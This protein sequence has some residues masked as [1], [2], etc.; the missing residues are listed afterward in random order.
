V[1]TTDRA[2]G[3]VLYAGAAALLVAGGLWWVHAK[4]DE[5]ATPAVAAWRA[6][7]ERLLPAPP[8]AEAVDTV[9]LSVGLDR[10]ID[11]RV[12]NGGHRLSVVCV[13]GSD[14]VL[15]ISLG[16][17]DSGRGLDCTGDQP[18]T[19]FDVGLAGQLRMN[20]SVGGTTP[21]IFRYAVVKT[22]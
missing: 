8:E 19:R 2:R 9:E 15:R 13:G 4:P 12:G 10:E 21:V 5:P 6:T 22:D 20:L 3:A 7:A 16:L 14:S 11:A 17:D 18:P 1:T